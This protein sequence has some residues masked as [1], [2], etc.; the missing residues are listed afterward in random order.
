MSHTADGS[1]TKRTWP[2][3]TLPDASCQVGCANKPSQACGGENQI[4]YA[5]FPHA[6]YVAPFVAFLPLSSAT[7]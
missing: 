5:I 3:A 6:R 4:V 2:N 7:V 1:D